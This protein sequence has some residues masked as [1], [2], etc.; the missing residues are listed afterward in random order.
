[1]NCMLIFYILATLVIIADIVWQ[2]YSKG[3]KKFI[4]NCIVFAEANIKG[5]QEKFDFVL[6]SLIGYLPLPLRLI[7]TKDALAQIIQDVFDITKKALDYK[8]IKEVE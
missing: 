6:T 1:M 5:N 3:L 2:I 7:L 4:V 8:N